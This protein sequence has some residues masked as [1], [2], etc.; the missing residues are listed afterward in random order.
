MLNVAG[1]QFACSAPT[2]ESFW[3]IIIF[4]HVALFEFSR[5]F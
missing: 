1:E 2:N 3:L 5:Q 4:A